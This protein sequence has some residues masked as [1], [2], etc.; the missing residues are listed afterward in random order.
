MDTSDKQINISLDAYTLYK[1]P[2]TSKCSRNIRNIGMICSVKPVLTED[3]CV[4][5]KE[6][7]SNVLYVRNVHLAKSQSHS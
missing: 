1:T 5:K 4:L 2:F 6:E 3:W 7:F